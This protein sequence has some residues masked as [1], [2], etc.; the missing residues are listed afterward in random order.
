MIMV[1]IILDLAK[2]VATIR[3]SKL[4]SVNGS[5]AKASTVVIYSSIIWVMII[6]T[7]AKSVALTLPSPLKSFR[8][9]DHHTSYP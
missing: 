5:S 9:V 1:M 2:S 7:I 8:L 6:L 4:K 3:R